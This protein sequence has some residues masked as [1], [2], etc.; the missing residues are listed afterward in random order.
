ME[1]LRPH[2]RSSASR[3]SDA[4]TRDATDERSQRGAAADGRGPL[5]VL[6]LL[7][8][9]RGLTGALQDAADH[10]QAAR[11]HPQLAGQRPRGL[12]ILQRLLRALLQ[13]ERG[14]VLLLAS[15]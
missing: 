2:Y 6:V 3:G 5:G 9:L 12:R 7:V 10:Q 1:T 11:A 14:V 4:A 8:D 13:V 15:S